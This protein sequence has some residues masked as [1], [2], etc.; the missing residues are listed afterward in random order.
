MYRGVWW[1]GESMS[2]GR[3]SGG[4]VGLNEDA[5]QEMLSKE[6]VDVVGSSDPCQRDKGAVGLVEVPICSC[7][8]EGRAGKIADN[9]SDSFGLSLE[10]WALEEKELA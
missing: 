6:S 3:R 5:Q 4:S 9:F 1:G 2:S 10:L 8:H 7:L